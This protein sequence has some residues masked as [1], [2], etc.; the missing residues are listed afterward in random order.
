MNYYPDGYLT[1]LLA[2]LENMIAVGIRNHS[3]A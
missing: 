1:L 2:Q 3:N